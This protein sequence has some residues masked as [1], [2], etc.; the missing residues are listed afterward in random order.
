MMEMLDDFNSGIPVF[1]DKNPKAC[2]TCYNKN[3]KMVY[4]DEE[5]DEFPQCFIEYFR[6]N[7]EGVFKFY[8]EAKES[9]SQFSR[10]LSA[11][12]EEITNFLNDELSIKASDFMSLTSRIKKFYSFYTEFNKEQEE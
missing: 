1:S 12:I 5:F 2:V 7:R 3:T 4:S 10:L 6:I 8:S 9:L 11:T